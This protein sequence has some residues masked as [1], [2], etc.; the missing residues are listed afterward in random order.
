MLQSKIR[1]SAKEVYEDWLSGV[2]SDNTKKNYKMIVPKM[3]KMLFDCEVDDIE[4]YMLANL[5]PVEVNKKVI[6]PMRKEYKNTTIINYLTV[7]KTFIQELERNRVYNLNYLYLKE[8]AL[9]VKKLKDDTVNREK[10]TPEIYDEMHEWMLNQKFSKRY[11]DKNKKY[12]LALEFMYV[13]AVRV[14][15][16]F[17]ELKWSNI[18][19]EKDFRGNET[20]VV[21][22]VDK[23]RKLNHKPISDEF[24]SELFE[25]MYKGS[26]NDLVFGELSKRTFTN[27]FNEFS[28]EKDY[29]ITP[30]SIKV[31]AG[32]RLYAMTND[33]VMTQRF[34][35]H[36][37]PKTTVR[38]IR[39]Q[40]DN[41]NTG[42]Y[43]L[44]SKITIDNVE[45]LGYDDLISILKDRK[46]LAYG[47]I[48]AA[49]ERGLLQK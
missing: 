13:T 36:N 2:D 17:C 9:S 29:D 10:M 47:V 45:E 22:V 3:T 15:A 14:N 32:T 46:D 1:V 43:I 41:N 19:R 35:D 44:S 39:T 28:V 23:G 33:I 4:E 5:T 42:S 26:D 27:M 31:G 30:H 16:T 18:R 37:D 49:K 48:H 34:L 38:Y 21:R 8:E 12:A 7:F 6:A 20:W 25:L 40:D 11:R 24:Y